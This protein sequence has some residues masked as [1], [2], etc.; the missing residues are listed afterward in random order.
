ME[1]QTTPPIRRDPSSTISHHD[2]HGV[3]AAD[4]APRVRRQR[5]RPHDALLQLLQPSDEHHQPPARHEHQRH[6]DDPDGQVQDQHHLAACTLTPLLCSC[7]SIWLLSSSL[8][9]GLLVTSLRSKGWP[10][11]S[12]R[13]QVLPL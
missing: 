9:S 12:L 5:P 7:S 4:A 13:G 1:S 6:W 11:P 3:E 8:L 10:V 2:A